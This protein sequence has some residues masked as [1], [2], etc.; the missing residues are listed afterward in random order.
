MIPSENETG[1]SLLSS[2]K[3]VKRLINKLI[4]KRRKHWKLYSPKQKKYFFS[5]HQYQ[6][7]DLG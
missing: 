6:L 4:G 5:N 2:T 3:N 7:K 1:D